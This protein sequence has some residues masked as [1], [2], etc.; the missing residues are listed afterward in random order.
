MLSLAA[1]VVGLGLSVLVGPLLLK[2]K[3]PMLSFIDIQ[4]PLD[5]RVGLLVSLLAGFAFGV[6]PALGISKV[7]V[8]SRL[9]DETPSSAATRGAAFG[10]RS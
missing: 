4:L 1:G 3:P 9:K 8:V 7:D 10:T 6:A 5:W 2:L